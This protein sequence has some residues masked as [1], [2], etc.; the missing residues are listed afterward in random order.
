[1]NVLMSMRLNFACSYLFFE[2][3]M[4]KTHQKAKK[5][6]KIKGFTMLKQMWKEC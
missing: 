5:P 3:F 2:K 1:M 6:N 4:L